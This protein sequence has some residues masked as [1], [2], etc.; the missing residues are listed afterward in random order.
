MEEKDAFDDEV[1]GPLDGAIESASEGTP[2]GAPKDGV[3]H[4]QISGGDLTKYWFTRK[5]ISKL[6]ITIDQF[7]LCLILEK[8]WKTTFQ[9]SNGL[10][11]GK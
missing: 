5:V 9:F 3:A 2:K 11:G 8:F 6:S 10:S 7:P 4:F 1:T